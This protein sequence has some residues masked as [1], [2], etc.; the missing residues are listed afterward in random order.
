VRC[1]PLGHDKKN[2]TGASYTRPCK[3]RKDGAP[4]VVALQANASECG[5]PAGFSYN[6]DDSKGYRKDVVISGDGRG[7]TW[8]R[9]WDGDPHDEQYVVHYQVLRTVCIDNC[10]YQLKLLEASG[11]MRPT[12]PGWNYSAPSKRQ[13]VSKP[14]SH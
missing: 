8:Y 14:P 6:R 3:K 11:R 2:G 12:K 13:Q 4:S 1:R 5:P 7:F 9:R 10:D